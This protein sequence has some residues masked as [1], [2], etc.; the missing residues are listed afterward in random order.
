MAD[1]E[2]PLN[3]IAIGADAAPAPAFLGGEEEAERLNAEIDALIPS[4][5]KSDTSASLAPLL[6]VIAQARTMGAEGAPPLK[7]F[8][9][10]LR[11]NRAFDDLYVLAS[12]MRAT[13]L[14]DEEVMRWEVQALTEL[15]VFETALELARTLVASRSDDMQVEAY[16]AIGRIYKQMYVDGRCGRSALEPALA[17]E[18]LRRAY[19]AYELAWSEAA[20]QPAEKRAYPA[21]NALAMAH[22]A[23]RDGAPIPGVDVD[24]MAQGVLAL[25]AAPVSA[26]GWASRA[27]A[28]LALGRPQ[29]AAQAYA[30][31]ALSSDVDLFTLTAALRQLE[32]VWR[33]DGDKPEGAPVRLLKAMLL[34]KMAAAPSK[35]A[36]P[37]GAEA[38]G[39][40]V[41]LSAQ[42][43]RAMASET[44]AILDAAKAQ[45]PGDPKGF[46]QLFTDNAPVAIEVV[47]NA[48]DRAR[49]VC[50]IHAM[51]GGADRAF[52]SGFMIRGS[53]LHPSWGDDPV[54]VTNN[55]VVST[56]PVG[57]SQRAEHCEAVFMGRDGKAGDRIR[58]KSVLWES[59]PDAH[60]VTVLRLDGPPPA[61]ARPLDALA[62]SALPPKA[63]NDDGIGRVYVIGFPAAGQLAFSFADNIWL[64]HD[65]PDVAD[66]QGDQA[67]VAR[68]LR[69]GPEP[70]RLHYKTPT[71]GGSSGSPVFDFNTFNL[72]GVH[73]R[74]LPGIPRLNNRPGTYAANQGV[75]IESI[76]A[77]I[78]ETLDGA[79]SSE[80]RRRWRAAAS[81]E[82]AT[83]APEAEAVTQ[84]FAA[85]IAGGAGAAPTPRF[86][87][88]A[89]GEAPGGASPVAA[90][91]LK[92]GKASPLDVERIGHESVIGV[93][94]R[95][96]IFDT[97]L[98]PWRMICAIRCWWG[99][100]LAVGTGFL[101]SPSLVLTAGHVVLPKALRTPPDRIEV[102][103][104]LNGQER[105]FGEA[106]VD[107]VSVHPGWRERFEIPSDVA[108][109]HLGEAIGRKVGWFGLATRTADEL[110]L[111]WSHVTGYPG[112]KLEPAR[113]AA[114]QAIAPAQAAQLWHHGA[115]ILNVQ[116]RRIF[117]A[118]D[119]TGGQS[120]APIYILE[121]GASPTPV[122]VGVHAYGAAASPVAVGQSNSGP[123]IDAE[124][125]DLITRWREASDDILRDRGQ[126]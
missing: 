3:R 92:A 90:Q 102:I 42:E 11:Q 115:P 108:A 104:G 4:L 2:A 121:P 109:I 18:Y 49:A 24:A 44:S 111:A 84:I 53:L 63:V 59:D 71:L 99:S 72:I 119:T 14:A 55:H 15:G 98:S 58:F 77:A 17:E 32:E 67:G 54:I 43:A 34:S 106:R 6:K 113:D 70:V 52:G 91:L 105:P 95:T 12:N 94:E 79:E 28:L 123:W 66:T 69:S 88:G 65:C 56:L 19:G 10:A 41:R 87:P 96:R 114:G 36:G 30:T 50:R 21:V 22:L 74:G 47:L 31:F 7:R 33:L 83:R 101:V 5:A 64:D 82:T 85:R 37:G 122:V 29:E 23:R 120:G 117:Y 93:D 103:F 8:A 1:D 35:S 86:S 76:R 16:S 25:V 89:M 51:M 112:E 39:A 27:E 107:S 68:A 78:A 124:M 45:T 48:L 125:F 81:I 116:T 97:Q 110:R 57:A 73:H 60:D 20:G 62:A 13:G 26:W 100:R 38:A 61:D 46:E 9:H 118:T 126:G 75:W 40:E 80:T